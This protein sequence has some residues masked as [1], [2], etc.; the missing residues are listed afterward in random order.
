[1]DEEAC[2]SVKIEEEATDMVGADELSAA[3]NAGKV[4]KLSLKST[5]D[6]YYM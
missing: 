2:I 6:L 4:G 5:C 1:M 3:A